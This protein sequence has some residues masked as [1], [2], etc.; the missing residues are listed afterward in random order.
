M[1]PT[2]NE[3]VARGPGSPEDDRDA[4]RHS[5]LKRLRTHGL[6]EKVGHRYK[7]YLAKL[8]RR[9]PATALNIR[10]SVVL[11]ALYDNSA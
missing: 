6:I 2:R 4:T 11:P 10:E 1:N 5:S 9:V 8:G 3:P 7:Y